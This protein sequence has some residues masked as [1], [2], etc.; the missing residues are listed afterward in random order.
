MVAPDAK[1]GR[2]TVIQPGVFIGNNVEIGQD[3]VL[4]AGVIVCDGTRIGNRVIV[5]PGAVIGGDAF[6]YKHRPEGYDRLLSSGHTV[7]EDDVEIGS[8]CTI[9]RGVSAPTTI[10]AGTKMDNHGHVGHDTV[11]GK[12]CLI[13]AQCGISGCVVIED[14]VT[15]W[16]QVGIASGLRIGSGAVIL[17]QSGVSKSLEGG[18]TY[19]GY[20]A[21]EATKLYK[22]EAYLRMLPAELKK[23]GF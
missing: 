19:F 7:L 14:K 20:P 9:D 13:A 12:E 6:Y 2:G 16:G 5:N 1:I 3:C 10:G 18:K 15:I 11:I 21:E 22:R 4:H 23:K 8:L 17:A